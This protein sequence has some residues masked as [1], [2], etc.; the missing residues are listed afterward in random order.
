MSAQE[1]YDLVRATP[2]GLPESELPVATAERLEALGAIY[3]HDGRYFAS[4][5][6]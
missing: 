3:E 5:D 1:A 2:F 6:V 4:P